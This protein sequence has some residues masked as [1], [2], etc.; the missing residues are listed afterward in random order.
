MTKNDWDKTFNSGGNFSKDK[1]TGEILNWGG[2]FKV[3]DFFIATDQKSTL[4]TA[5]K[6]LESGHIPQAMIDNAIGKMI[7]ILSYRNKKDK[8]STWNQVFAPKR[9]R[10]SMKNYFLNQWKKSKSKSNGPFPSNYKADDEERSNDFNYGANTETNTN[11][12]YGNL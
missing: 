10:E 9:D 2:A 12:D 3:R 4:E 7:L 11:Q 6:E 8:T 5:L 1:M